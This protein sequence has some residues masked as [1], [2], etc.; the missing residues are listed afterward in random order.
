MWGVV[1]ANHRADRA[2]E[3]QCP[4][5]ALHAQES[6]PLTTPAAQGRNVIKQT[7]SSRIPRPPHWLC[8]FPLQWTDTRALKLDRDSKA[9]LLT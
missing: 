5:D 6:C 8:A 3:M 2:K 4:E 7:Q 1:K 9:L